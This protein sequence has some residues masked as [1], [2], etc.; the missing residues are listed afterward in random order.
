MNRN[1]STNKE[2]L[3]LASQLIFNNFCIRMLFIV[4]TASLLFQF[5]ILL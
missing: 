2:K 1:P 3:N 5:L 4:Q